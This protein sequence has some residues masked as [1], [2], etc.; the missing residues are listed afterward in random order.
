MGSSGFLIIFAGVNFANAR[1]ANRTGAKRWISLIGSLL[2]LLALAILIVQRALKSPQELWVLLA[3]VGFAFI[4]EF[5]YRK[6][7]SRTIKSSIRG[8]D[9]TILRK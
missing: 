2:C 7:T 3:M 4:T 5:I 6:S 8:P 1:M 9:V